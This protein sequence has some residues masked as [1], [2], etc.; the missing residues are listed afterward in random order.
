MSSFYNFNDAPEYREAGQLLPDGEHVWVQGV[1]KPGNVSLPGFNAPED[2]GLFTQAKG[3]DL[4]YLTWEFKVISPPYEGA[5]IFTNMMMHGGQVDDKG[6]SKSGNISKGFIR[7]MIESAFGIHPKDETA[8]AQQYRQIPYLRVLESL[9]FPVRLGIDEGQVNPENGT[10]FPDRNYIAKIILSDDEEY[11]PMRAGHPV[12][13]KPRGVRPARNRGGAA[14]GG[15]A[16]QQ[17]GML[18]QNEAAAIAGTR[19]AAP[20]PA[21]APAYAQPAPAYQPAPFQP[22]PAP[23]APA[24]AP[25]YPAPAAPAPAP[26]AAPPPPSAA[27]AAITA[28]PPAPPPV[29]PPPPPVAAAAPVTPAQAWVAPPAQGAPAAAPIA[30][31]G[32]GPSWLQ[33]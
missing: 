31:A 26:Y 4:V 20:A 28:P 11:A 3:S 29:Y 32:E 23:A 24:P 27:P 1:I 10:K 15:G 8:T 6:Q 33:R 21:P 5:M 18:W 19:T 12:A 14:A 25:A 9:K 22:A 16:G 2:Q 7:G 30:P 13:P 17:G